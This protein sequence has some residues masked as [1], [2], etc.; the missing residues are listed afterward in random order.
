MKATPYKVSRAGPTETLVFVTQR[1]DALQPKISASNEFEGGP[2]KNIL[3]AGFEAA[4][5][6]GASVGIYV[7]GLLILVLNGFAG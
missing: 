4:M 2:V 6:A 3:A 5:A 1:L 7:A